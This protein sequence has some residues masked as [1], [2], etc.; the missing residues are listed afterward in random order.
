[1]AAGVQCDTVRRGTAATQLPGV[2]PL[3]GC[4]A[5]RNTV[6][7]ADVMLVAAGMHAAGSEAHGPGP[8]LLT[9][10]DVLSLVTLL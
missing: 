5:H 7:H 3:A 1:M 9:M 6:P 4:P 8:V 2:H 10:V